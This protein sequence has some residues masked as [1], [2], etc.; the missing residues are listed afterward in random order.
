MLLVRHAM[1]DACGRFLA[2]R[3]PG[4]HLND[5][6]RRQA[7]AL[8]GALRRSVAAVYCSPIERARET[9][10]AIAPPGMRPE[11]VEDLTEID[12]GDWTGRSFDDL[13]RRPDWVEFN[14]RRSAA[15]IPNGEWM[16]DVQARACRALE[17]IGR[18]HPSQTVAIVSHGDVL[19]SI[20]A[21]VIDLP[22]DRLDAF[23]IDP[24]SV[25]AVERESDRFVLAQLNDHAYCDYRCSTHA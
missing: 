19:R 7:A 17:R 2:G 14:Q 16:L 3:A 21:K 10:D 11:V 24:A 18:A 9:A 12:F 15:R 5:E 20:V 25:S 8:G 22:L 1:V 23:R 6:G 4:I 13:N